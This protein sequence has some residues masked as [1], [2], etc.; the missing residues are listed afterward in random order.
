MPPMSQEYAH[1]VF[2]T[3]GWEPVITDTLSEEII[4][5]LDRNFKIMGSEVILAK[6][7]KEHIH[8]LIRLKGSVPLSKVIGWV[9]GECSHHLNKHLTGDKFYWQKGYWANWIESKKME[10]TKKYILDQI[11]YHENTSF[12]EEMSLLRSR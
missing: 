10:E 3:K 2:A 1:I 7:V 6:A 8:V 11:A 12:N 9:K 4:R 5:R